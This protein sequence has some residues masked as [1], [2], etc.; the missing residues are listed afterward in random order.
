ME[1]RRE[2]PHQM[3]LPGFSALAGVL[4]ATLNQSSGSI[5]PMFN[6]GRPRTPLQWI[7]HIVLGIVALML[8]MWMLRVFV[9]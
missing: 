1:N 5:A 4:P 8:V 9:L 2:F 6:F 3:Q 7:G